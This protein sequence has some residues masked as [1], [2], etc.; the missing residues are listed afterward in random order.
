MKEQ[1]IVVK[2]YEDGSFDA[3][4]FDF[5]GT[6]CVDELSRLMRDLAVVTKSEKKPEY[7]KNKTVVTNQVKQKR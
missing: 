2:V 5:E 3:E 1:K 4:T 7:Y 6:D